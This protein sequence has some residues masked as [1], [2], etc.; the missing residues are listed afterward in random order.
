MLRHQNRR[1]AADSTF[2]RM[3]VLQKISIGKSLKHMTVAAMMNTIAN[4]NQSSS[5]TVNDTNNNTGH[6]IRKAANPAYPLSID[7]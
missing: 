4:N 2:T 1:Q 7:R 6:T 3:P 5:A